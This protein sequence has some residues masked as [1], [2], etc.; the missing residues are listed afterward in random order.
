MKN[1]VGGSRIIDVVDVATQKGSSL[2]VSDFVEYY[3][4]EPRNK[5]LNV[6]SLEF[7]NTPMDELITSPTLVSITSTYHHSSQVFNR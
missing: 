3:E 6:L 1:L 7:S 2:P 4:S 5:L